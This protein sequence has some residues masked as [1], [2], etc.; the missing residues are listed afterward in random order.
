MSEAERNLDESATAEK[1][2]RKREVERANKIFDCNGINADMVECMVQTL[3]EGLHT[4]NEDMR[5]LLYCAYR[6]AR[7]IEMECRK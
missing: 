3:A 7:A 1:I 2:A 5:S 4:G 6:N